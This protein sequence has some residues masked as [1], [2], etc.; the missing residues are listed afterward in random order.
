MKNILSTRSQEYQKIAV[1]NAVFF[2]IGVTP[3]VSQS[4]S[5]NPTGASPDASAMLDVNSVDKGLLVPRMTA[6]QRLGIVEPATGLIVY[7][8]DAAAGFYYNGGTPSA[9]SWVLLIAGPVK[10]S[11]IAS[12][13]QTTTN[14][15]LVLGNDNNAGAELRLQEPCQSGQHYSS[16]KAQAQDQNVTYTLPS[17]PPANNEVLKAQSV[18]DNVVMLDWALPTN[19]GVNM[20]RTDVAISSVNAVIDVTGKSFLRITAAPGAFNLTGFQGGVDGQ[21]ILIVN[22][23]GKSMTYI[24]EDTTTPAINRIQTPSNS[25]IIKLGGTISTMFIYDGAQGRWRLI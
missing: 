3:I 12:G 14:T 18:T 10:G 20:T 11:D 7:Q 22:T 15:T 21:L 17:A 9:P 23:S 16:F 2:L 13:V 4:I 6:D 25:N 24:N 1:L 5:I 19:A 8:T